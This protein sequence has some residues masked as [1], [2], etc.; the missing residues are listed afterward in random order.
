MK[1]RN[2]SK[3][4]KTIVMSLVVVM[5]IGLLSGCGS[6]GNS[7]TTETTETTDKTESTETNTKNMND[8]SAK[9]LDE[10]TVTQK[11][12]ENYDLTMVNIWATWCGSCVD[13]LPEL[14]KVYEGLPENVNMIGICVDGDESYD[15]AKQAIEQNGTTYKVL[16]P[17]DK[18]KKSL[19][20]SIDALPTTIF[21]DKEGNI[22]GD[23]QI[24]V[25]ELDSTSLAN[26]YNMLIENTLKLVDTSTSDNSD[27]K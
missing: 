22:V 17:D 1:M 26:G 10:Q 25:P 6:I 13:E 5:S 9:T 2:T 23:E 20:D 16:I 24:G 12:F 27:N 15:L 18:L 3:R 8:F 14:E 21:V 4:V 11:D 7:E 19:T